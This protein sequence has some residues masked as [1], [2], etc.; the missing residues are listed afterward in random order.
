MQQAV[1]LDP[2]SPVA[3]M[4]LGHLFLFRRE[5]ERAVQQYRR[6]IEVDPTFHEGR[7]ALGFFYLSRGQPQQAAVAFPEIPATRADRDVLA[8]ILAGR[9]AEAQAALDR[10]E[11][12]SRFRYVSAVDLAVLNV[13]VGRNQ[14]ALDWLEQGFR[15]R[16]TDMMFLK[17]TPWFDKLRSEPRFQELLRKMNLA[18]GAAASS[19]AATSASRE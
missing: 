7:I 13:L 16:A 5:D 1:Q 19:A 17:V 10:I 2:L 9:R 14:Q 8:H 15:D 3:N 11:Q 4:S 6:T 12:L 18:G